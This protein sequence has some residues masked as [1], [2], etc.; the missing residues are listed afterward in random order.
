MSQKAS[1]NH[2]S[3]NQPFFVFFCRI[4]C[5]ETSS[6]PEIGPRRILPRANLPTTPLRI[7]Q[8]S[9]MQLFPSLRSAQ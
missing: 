3:H 5:S 9:Q 1:V 7:F 8:R 2:D 4:I 6:D